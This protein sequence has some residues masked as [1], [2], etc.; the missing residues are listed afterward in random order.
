M[1]LV[2]TSDRQGIHSSALVS[3]FANAH[4]TLLLC[5]AITPVLACDLVLQIEYLSA[6]SSDDIIL[7]IDSPG[8]SVAAGL[9]IYDAMQRSRCDIVTVCLGTAASM[10]AVLAAAGTRGK[11]YC[12]PHGELMIHQVLGGIQGQ[13]SDIEI[14]ASRLLARKELLNQLLAAACGRTTEEVRRDCDRDH[15]MTA[16]E[17]IAYGLIDHIYRQSQ[18]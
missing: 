9:S 4:R 7:Y 8:G 16:D 13:A 15:Y 12:T 2:S 1:I 17:A 10:A 18:L 5:G 11:R 6:K 3:Y 14:A